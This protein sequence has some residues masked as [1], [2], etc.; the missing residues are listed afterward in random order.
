MT[1]KLLNIDW[2]HLFEGQ[3]M[4]AMW[5]CFHTKLL[6]ISTFQLKLLTP[7]LNPNGWICL[8]SK[9]LSLNIKFGIFIRPP[10]IMR[11]SNIATTA[12]KHAKSSFET[13]LAKDIQQKPNLVLE[14]C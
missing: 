12:V 14:I 6:L 2:A 3:D 10:D 9:R 4:D 11:T 1:H 5:L 7:N 8:H 13:K